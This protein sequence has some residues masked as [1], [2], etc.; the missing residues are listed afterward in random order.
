M[1]AWGLTLILHNANIPVDVKVR[2]PL[3]AGPAA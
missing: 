2:L 3:R 1:S